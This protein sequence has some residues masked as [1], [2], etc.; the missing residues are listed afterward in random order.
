MRG[1][2]GSLYAGMAKLADARD[3]KSLGVN[4]Y[5]FKSGYPHHLGEKYLANYGGL[6]E[7]V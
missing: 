4:P 7:L 1:G 6:S 3:L 5:Q 2:D